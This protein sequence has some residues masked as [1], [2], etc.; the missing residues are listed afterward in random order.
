[1]PDSPLPPVPK[2]DLPVAGSEPVAPSVAPVGSALFG[3]RTTFHYRQSVALT[4]E[5]TDYPRLTSLVR[6]LAPGSGTAREFGGGLL[7]EHDSGYS[8]LSLTIVPEPTA[9]VIRADLRLETRQFAYFGG[10]VAGAF[11]TSLIATNYLPGWQALA[12]GLG[13]LAPFA[14]IARALWNASAR[15]SAAAV[16]TL[17]DLVAAAMRGELD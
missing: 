16:K 1:M 6:T 17:V 5:P 8:A 12:V 4:L 14:V 10:A 9:T 3:S 7:W 15:R 13:S 2:A 11:L